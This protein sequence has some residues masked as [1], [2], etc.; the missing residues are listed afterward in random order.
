MSGIVENIKRIQTEL[1]QGVTLVAVSKFHPI[2]ALK[3]AYDCGQR[4]FAES[5]AQE[6]MQKVD[7]MPADTV[8]HFI[9]HLQTNKVKAVL[10]HVAMIQSVDSEKLLT[11]INAEARKEERRIDVLLELH[12]A[13]EE[14]KFGFSVEDCERLVNSGTLAEM[15]GVRVRGVMGMATNTDDDGEIRREFQAIR[16]VFDRLKGG[17]MK[18]NVDFSVVSMGMSNDYPLAIMEKTTM[19]RLGSCIFGPRQ[20]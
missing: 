12:V 7:K 14:T 10:P 19:V 11:A 13:Q 6:L 18:E 4:I 3:E 16:S 2:E 17:C 20:Y 8:W 15:T 9:G 5:R 1:P